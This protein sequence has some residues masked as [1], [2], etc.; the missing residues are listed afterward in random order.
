MET[1]TACMDCRV[2]G[3]PHAAEPKAR[4]PIPARNAE[5]LDPAAAAGPAC[6]PKTDRAEDTPGRW[7]VLAQM[8]T[9]EVQHCDRLT[10]L[11]K[12]QRQDLQ[13]I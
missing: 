7:E 9:E 2:G 12:A 3:E 10:W 13:H 4:S 11:S 5:I 6:R 1:N 8:L